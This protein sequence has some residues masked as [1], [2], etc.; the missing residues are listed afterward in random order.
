MSLIVGNL[1]R[2]L[3]AVHRCIVVFVFVMFVLCFVVS[4]VQQSNG[5]EIEVCHAVSSFCAVMLHVDVH[6]PAVWNN[7]L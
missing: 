2:G 7:L 6:V 3:V 5:S 4:F 1:R